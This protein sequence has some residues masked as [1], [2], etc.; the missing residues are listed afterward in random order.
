MSGDT[1]SETDL[2]AEPFDGDHAYRKVDVDEIADVPSPTTHKKEVDEAVGATTFG[3]NVYEV[4]PGEEVPWGYHYHPEH[5]ELFYVLE[6]TLHVKTP[7]GEYE[8]GADEAFFVPAG[9]PNFAYADDERVRF[10]AVGAPKESDQAVIR[11]TCPECGE[12]TGRD[13]EV[14]E[15]GG[16]VVYVLHCAEC[17]AEAKRFASGP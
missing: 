10:V 2:D 9:A 7:D 17:G 16:E 13:Y 14:L 5:E 6:G 11:E 15:E 4:A 12:A 8:V 3:F 1:E